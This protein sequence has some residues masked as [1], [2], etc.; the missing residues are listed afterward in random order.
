MKSSASSSGQG[1]ASSFS[2]AARLVCGI[3]RGNGI[4]PPFFPARGLSARGLPVG[5]GRVPFAS[6]TVSAA[7]ACVADRSSGVASV[8]CRTDSGRG[9]AVA[10]ETRAAASEARDGGSTGSAPSSSGASRTTI[11][12]GISTIA[13]VPPYGEARR[14]TVMPC[15]LASLA[16]TNMPSRRSSASATTSNC[17]GT[18]SWAL[19]AV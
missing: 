2:S 15:R 17:G 4:R 18:A 9:S 6:S 13:V 12:S 10:A 19:N 11:S 1:P 8:S 7:R 5:T 3:R 16:M 14:V